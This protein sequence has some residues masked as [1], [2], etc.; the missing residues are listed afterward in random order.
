MTELTAPPALDQLVVRIVVDNETDTLSSV[1][2]GVP[3]VPE[4]FSAVGRTTPTRTYEGHD[5]YP[6]FDHLCVACHGFSALITARLGDA[7][8]TVL[9]DVGPDADVW[10][11]NA[12]RLG[13]DLATIETVFLSHWHHDHRGRFPGAVAAIAAARSAAGLPEPMVDLHPHRP[14]QRG[15]LS[16]LGL[17]VTLPPEPTF[18]EIVSGGGRVDLHGDAHLL[19]GGLVFGSGEI[20]RV[21]AY[22]T[23]LPRHLRFDGEVGTPDELILDERYLAAHVRGRGVTVFSA[24]SHAGVVNACLSAKD[25]VPGAPVDL[26]IGGY[27][28]AGAEMEDRIDATLRD[29]NELIAPRVLAPGHCTG[30]RAKAA[31]A[32]AFTPGRYGPSVVGTTYTLVAD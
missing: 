19:A 25:Q 31:L 2:P 9:F 18:D 10:L 20:P 27:H 14:D 1:E 12:E 32:A 8:H 11:G 23:G 7:T 15:T 29:L 17:V 30:W 4:I 24:C 26:V 3:Q 22:E 21:T 5:C 6:A 13:V 28:L 16:P